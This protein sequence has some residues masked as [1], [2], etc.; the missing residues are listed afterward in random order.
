MSAVAPYYI[1]AANSPAS[2]AGIHLPDDVIRQRIV[3]I[4]EHAYSCEHHYALGNSH[5]REAEERKR[6]NVRFSLK[7]PSG[8]TPAPDQ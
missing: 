4:G 3:C 6:R 5:K 7:L 2:C 1:P 8:N